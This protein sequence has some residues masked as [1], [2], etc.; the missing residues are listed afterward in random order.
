MTHFIRAKVFLRRK[1]AGAHFVAI[2]YQSLVYVRSNLG[3]L[4]AERRHMLLEMRVVG[5][6]QKICIEDEEVISFQR[7]LLDDAM[8]RDRQALGLLCEVLLRFR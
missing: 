7:D 4:L 1:Y 6:S 2:V 5:Y 8:Y 3:V